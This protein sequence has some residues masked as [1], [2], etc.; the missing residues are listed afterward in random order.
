MA[1]GKPPWRIVFDA[2][3]RSVATPLETIVRSELFFDLVALST[4]TRKGTVARTER[5]S[6]RALHLMNLPAG[7][8]MRRLGEQVTR[9]ERRVMSL[10]KQLEVTTAGASNGASAHELAERVG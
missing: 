4:R 8:D 1:T 7:S 3:E 2:V 6:R 10:S 5:L 9:L